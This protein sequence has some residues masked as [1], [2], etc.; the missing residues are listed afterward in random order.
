MNKGA[1]MMEELHRVKRQKHKMYSPY[2][3]SQSNKLKTNL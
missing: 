1:E 3:D 2:G